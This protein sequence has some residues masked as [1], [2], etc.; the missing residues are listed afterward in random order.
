M[1]CIVLCTLSILFCQQLAAAD[2]DSSFMPLV[3]EKQKK[4]NKNI[5][6]AVI[7]DLNNENVTDKKIAKVLQKA[8]RLEKLSAQ[9]HALENPYLSS[10]SLTTLDL[11]RGSLKEFALLKHLLHMPALRDLNLSHN[12]ISSLSSPNQQNYLHSDARYSFYDLDVSHNRLQVLDMQL[13][14]RLDTLQNVNLSDNPLEE[15]NHVEKSCGGI[16]LRDRLLFASATVKLHNTKLSSEDQELLRTEYGTLQE[17]GTYIVLKRGAG[18]CGVFTG[19]FL[20]PVVASPFIIL[21]HTNLSLFLPLAIGF[22]WSSI[23]A[24]YP[25]GTWIYNRCTPDDERFMYYFVFKFNKNPSSNKSDT[26]IQM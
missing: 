9:Y 21:A 22:G 12:E 23:I 17:E 1:Q 14:D 16:V 2:S 13:L 8:C 20:A 19:A 26:L 18:M 6:Y 3:Q 4:T 24:G 11:S 5:E 10:H 7:L 25:V 15:I